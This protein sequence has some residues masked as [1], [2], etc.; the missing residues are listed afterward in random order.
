MYKKS[1]KAG[2]VWGLVILGLIIIITAI[3]IVGNQD[4][5]SDFFSGIS[6]ENSVSLVETI[7]GE[8]TG[9]T[10]TALTVLG[11]IT[12]DIPEILIDS[13]NGV[14]AVIVVVA[15]WI[16]IFLIFGD[17]LRTFG[18]FDERIAWSVAALMAIIGANLKFMTLIAA[19]MTALFLPLGIFAAYFG[20]FAAFALFIAFEWGMDGI[21]AR[22]VEKRMAKDALRG[23]E[24][25]NT[26]N[27]AINFLR[28]VG[29]NVQN[30]QP[31]E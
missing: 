17:I 6:V 29:G 8:I 9:P 31:G 11:Y 4:Y 10:E 7:G 28:G 21:A 24:T 2:N 3:V 5:Y 27:N 26:V 30:E 20:I 14:S 18:S 1:K 16:M 22:V 23:R 15:I 19:S 25:T 13:S 12:G